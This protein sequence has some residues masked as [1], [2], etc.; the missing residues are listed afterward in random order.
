MMD[1]GLAQSM[2]PQGDMGGDRQMMVQQVVAMLME[3][4][5]P[6]ELLQQG[7]PMDVIE[8]A[9]NILLAQE[10]GMNTA[11]AAPVTDAGLAMTMG[12]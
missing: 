9:I 3:G 7:V 6:E 11:Q 1:Q 12:M 8:E 2:A 5:D 4:M 10:Q